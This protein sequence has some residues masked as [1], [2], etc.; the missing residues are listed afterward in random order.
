MALALLVLLLG[1]MILPIPCFCLLHS[2]AADITKKY[3]FIQWHAS[4]EG[5]YHPEYLPPNCKKAFK[6][7]LLQL[8]ASVI[9]CAYIIAATL[10][11]FGD[12]LQ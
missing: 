2:F 6:Q 5:A 10:A 8:H 11:N 1:P 4:A 9:C 7:F 3:C 12:L